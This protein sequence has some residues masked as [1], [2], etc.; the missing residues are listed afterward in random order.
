MLDTTLKE[1]FIVRRVIIQRGEKEKNKIDFGGGNLK[2]KYIL[3]KSLQH[4]LIL[5]DNKEKLYN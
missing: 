2:K 5:L 3:N 4:I 1:F